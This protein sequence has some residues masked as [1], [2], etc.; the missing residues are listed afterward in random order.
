MHRRRQRITLLIDDYK[1]GVVKELI[2]D[3]LGLKSK[4]QIFIEK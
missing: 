4:F 1:L 3:R 2:L